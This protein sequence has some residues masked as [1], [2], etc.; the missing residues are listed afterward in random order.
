MSSRPCIWSISGHS[1]G[2]RSG[3]SGRSDC[4]GAR[5]GKILGGCVAA[6][7][8]A[9]DA[10]Q[11]LYLDLGMKRLSDFVAARIERAES[12]ASAIRAHALCYASIRETTL[13]IRG[14]LEIDD[15]EVF[16]ERSGYADH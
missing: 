1:P 6:P 16:L 4:G 3:L 8:S 2:S 5:A 10:F 13:R 7:A 9:G 14:I 15:F 11:E 12:L